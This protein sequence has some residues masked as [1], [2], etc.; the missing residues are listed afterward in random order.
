MYAKF[1]KWFF[2][3][4]A[5]LGAVGSA[6]IFALA[7]RNKSSSGSVKTGLNTNNNDIRQQLDTDRK[8][9]EAARDNLEEAQ[10]L[11]QRMDSLN[12]ESKQSTRR[13][14]HIIKDTRNSV[15]EIIRAAKAGN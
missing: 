7:G 11:T 10:R 3:C 4:I 8:R 15:S 1:K 6:V 9:E 14:G 12:E 2:V 13:T 5:I